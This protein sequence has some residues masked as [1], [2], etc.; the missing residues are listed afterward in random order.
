MVV[1]LLLQLVAGGQ[2][3]R[4]R[5]Q[6][7]LFL[8]SHQQTSHLRLISQPNMSGSGGGQQDLPQVQATLTLRSSSS[9][10]SRLSCQVACAAQLLPAPPPVRVCHLCTSSDTPL[11]VAHRVV[12]Q[13]AAAAVVV[14]HNNALCLPR[15]A[16]HMYRQQ[17]MQYSASPGQATLVCWCLLQLHLLAGAQ[18]QQQHSSCRLSSSV[19]G[20]QRCAGRQQQ[21]PHRQRLSHAVLPVL[22]HLHLHLLLLP[23]PPCCQSRRCASLRC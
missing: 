23:P 11:L 6:Q 7:H 2:Q 21:H 20:L 4:R 5:Q 22:L 12:A 15:R 3:H 13:L 17:C 8:H 18:Q 16:C 1:V 10:R 19:R 9:S 14:V